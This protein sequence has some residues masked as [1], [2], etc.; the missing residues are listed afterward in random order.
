MCRSQHDPRPGA[1]RRA[2]RGGAGHVHHAVRDDLPDQP[3]DGRQGVLRAGRGRGALQAPRPRD[4]RRARAP[5]S[6]CSTNTAST[7]SRTSWPRPCSRRTSSGSPPT[8]SS[9]TYWAPT[10]SEAA[11]GETRR[12]HD[13]RTFRRTAGRR[14]RP[15]R[16]GPQDAAERDPGQGRGQHRARRRHGHDPARDHH[17]GARPQRCR[18]DDDALAAGGVH[19]ADERHR[20]RRA[21][22]RGGGPVGEPVDH[23]GHAARPRE[24]RPDERR[25]GLDLAQVLRRHAA[26]LECRDGGTPAG[27]VRG[28][29]PQEPVG[30][31]PRQAV[32]D[33][34]HHRPGHARAADDLRRGVPRHGRT[35]AVRV[36]RRAPGRLRGAPAHHP[37]LQPPGRGGRAA[38]RG[39]HGHRQRARAPGGARRPDAGAGIQPHGRR[40]TP[41]SGSRTD[42]G[43]CIAS[44]SATPSRSPWRERSATTSWPRPVR[45]ASRW[46]PCR[47]RTSSSAS[48]IRGACRHERHD[49]PP[50]SRGRRPGRAGP[51]GRGTRSPAGGRCHDPH[52]PHDRRAG[53]G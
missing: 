16:Q 18:Q 46:A 14:R 41:S 26:R 13:D 4:V 52:R 33:R 45:P 23:L 11:T 22:G 9:R 6:G 19:P 10:A 48:P 36:L 40:R 25:E 3:R 20:R 50:G 17:R 34:G 15:V 53:T 37:A 8:R 5:G 38:V 49:G 42:A 51:R 47:C 39:R 2:R 24:R 27:P 43:C 7:T 29:R 35:H 44:S 1:L 30:P 31:V 21:G 28:E 32:G 12:S